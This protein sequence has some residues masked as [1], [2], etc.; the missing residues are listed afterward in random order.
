MFNNL[1]SRFQDKEIFEFAAI[2]ISLFLAYIFGVE[3]EYLYSFIILLFFIFII[4]LKGTIYIVHKK[5]GGIISNIELK[6]LI[7]YYEEDNKTVDLIKDEFSNKDS[8]LSINLLK[9]PLDGEIKPIDKEIE[10]I[11]IVWNEQIQNKLINIIHSWGENNKNLPIII[12]LKD[13]KKNTQS[14][15]YILKPLIE[16]FRIV[17]YD[18]SKIGDYIK[19]LLLRSIE[20]SR[21]IAK[22]SGF[23]KRLAVFVF[24]IWITTASFLLYFYFFKDVKQF[25]KN[26]EKMEMYL[27][28]LNL[29]NSLS[30]L[31]SSNIA[32]EQYK[33][34][35]NSYINIY[36]KILEKETSSNITISLWR[37]FNNSDSIYKISTTGSKTFTKFPANNSTLLGDMYLYSKSDFN[38]PIIIKYTNSNNY[39]IKNNNSII[40]WYTDGS[41]KKDLDGFN[42]EQLKNDTT[43]KGLLCYG[44]T[45]NN[46][47]YGLTIDFDNNSNFLESQEIR[48]IM[49]EIL[50]YTEFLP[51]NFFLFIKNEKNINEL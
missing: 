48:N 41:E 45:K 49:I 3:Q 43:R 51:N 10:G 47:F 4:F 12:L 17:V 20:R 2:G 29:K 37:T 35:L 15:N 38:K 8:N 5:D 42:Y 11:Y 1:V 46:I 26:E 9:I 14:N 50:F 30:L 23:W 21:K 13:E 6:I 34:I 22:I 19:Y 25:E 31:D 24:L 32:Q 44:Y 16:R 27:N 18:E 28:L 7:I 39:I 33:K 36:K 40:S